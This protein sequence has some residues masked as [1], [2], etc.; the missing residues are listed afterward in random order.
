VIV[1]GSSAGLEPTHAQEGKRAIGWTT[2]SIPESR[3]RVDYPATVFSISEGKSENGTG[4]RFQTG[5]R[6]ASLSIYSIPND[7]DETPAAYLKTNLRR[8]RSALQHEQVTS[9]FFTISEET[10]DTVYYSRCNFSDRT[11]HCFDLISP[12]RE[13]RAWNSIVTRIS[14]SL[15]PLGS[16]RLLPG[17][18]QEG[19][20]TLGWAVFSIPQSGTRVDYPANI[21]SISEGKSENGIR[22]RFRTSDGRASLSI[23]S[24]AN[25]AGETPASYL[26]TNLR[27]PRSALDYERVTSSFFAISEETEETI[28]YSRCNFSNNNRT[29]HCFDLIYPFREERAWDPIVTRISRSLRPLRR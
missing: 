1:F 17:H 11:I 15:R 5:D 6:R 18:A 10:K 24:T 3:T 21:F 9:S 23:Y 14:R 19:K 8:P 22:Q 13:K 4:Q 25:D 28:Y 20:G 16:A 12:F 27:R 26:R 2:F 29:I 7:A